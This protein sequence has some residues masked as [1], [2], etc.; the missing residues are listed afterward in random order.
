MTLAEADDVL[1]T[2]G[3]RYLNFIPMGSYDVIVYFYRANVECNVWRTNSAS[4]RITE[5]C[6]NKTRAGVERALAEAQA[7]AVLELCP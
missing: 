4:K 7:D 6:L 2:A 1:R 5:M 3:F